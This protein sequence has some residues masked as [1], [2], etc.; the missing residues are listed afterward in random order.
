ML[1]GLFSKGFE[2]NSKINGI[3]GGLEEY[4]GETV[5]EKIENYL[6]SVGV[7]KEQIEM[8]RNIFLED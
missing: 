6:L 4:N 7:T 3:F 5:N 8:I 1:T 2:N